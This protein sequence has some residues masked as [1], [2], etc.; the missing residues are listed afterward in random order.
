M[1]SRIHKYAF[2]TLLLAVY[3]IFFS[4]ES[5]YNFEGH[6]EA[7]EILHRAT[8]IQTAASLST[9]S[10]AAYPGAHGIRV[11]LNKRFHPE[12]FPPCKVVTAPIPPVYVPRQDPSDYAVRPLP[13]I[14]VSHPPLRGPPPVA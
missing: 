5:F 14:A 2:Y 6:S 12:S 3:S 4:I 11:R 9:T 1:G 8:H 13:A 10:H 7:R